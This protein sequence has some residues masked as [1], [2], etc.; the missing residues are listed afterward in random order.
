MKI[1]GRL[2]SQ[3]ILGKLKIEVVGL[4]KQNVFPYI[5]VILLINDPSTLSYIKQKRLKSEEIGA[6]IT[7][8]DSNPDISEEELIKKIDELNNDPLVHG[9]IVQ[10]PLPKRFNEEKITYAINSQKDIDGFRK[11]SKFGIPVGLAVIRLLRT[12]H[13]DNFESWLKTNNITV[14]GK[15]LTAGYTVIKTLEN[16]GIKP[17]VISSKTERANDAIKDS[18]IVISCVGKQKIVNANNLKK[19][20]ILIGVGMHMENDKLK[21]D[22]EEAEIEKIASFYS[23]TPGGVGPVNVSCLLVNLLEASKNSLTK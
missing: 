1:D 9:I 22:F 21:G 20:A 11:D 6:K 17:N 13:P 23:P 3:Q 18:D 8:D 19:S 7:I 14:I 12:C 10:R 2:L 15:G 5:Y 4:K 16:L